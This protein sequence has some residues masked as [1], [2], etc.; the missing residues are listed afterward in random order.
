MFPNPMM[1]RSL[2][3]DVLLAQNIQA[4]LHARREDA[5]SL[6]IWCGHSGAW[7][8]KVISGERGIPIRELGKVADFFGITVPDLFQSGISSLTER[9][10]T[11]D[12]RRSE[13]RSDQDRRQTV[14]GERGL[15]HE[16]RPFPKRAEPK[17]TER[18][19]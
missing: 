12:R 10:R 19:G 18:T 2:R 9:R 6:A 8:S 16:V 7:I 15:H 3:A 1:K 5:K 4:L 14:I 11:D 13:R 17:K